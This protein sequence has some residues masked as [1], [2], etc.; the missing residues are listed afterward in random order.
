M[1]TI[2]ADSAKKLAGLQCDLLGKFRSGSVRLEQLEWFNLLPRVLREALS[3]ISNDALREEVMHF[4]MEKEFELA[5]DLGVITVPKSYRHST[6]LDDFL[7]RNQN[8]FKYAKD[9]FRQVAPSTVLHPNEQFAVAAYR[10]RYASGP[11]PPQECLTFIELLGG[12]GVGAEGASLVL[13]QLWG[14]LY[15]DQ[16]YLTFDDPD[17]LSIFAL[18]ERRVSVIKASMNIENPARTWSFGFSPYRDGLCEGELLL[19]FRPLKQEKR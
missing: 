15:T 16:R 3:I 18:D 19:C 12:V 1:N 17:H 9:M 4:F 6:R 5:Q 14:E 8:R 13:E 7:R 11:M 10:S 2:D